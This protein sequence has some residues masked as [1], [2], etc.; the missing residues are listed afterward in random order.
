MSDTILN[1]D[2]SVYMTFPLSGALSPSDLEGWTVRTIT[3][4]DTESGTVALITTECESFRGLLR[5][6]GAFR[7]CYANGFGREVHTAFGKGVRHYRWTW[8][9]FTPSGERQTD[10]VIA[11]RI[12]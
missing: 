9:H 3:S 5:H 4:A 12:H 6:V 1:E 10:T 2:G 7:D 8:E 11:S